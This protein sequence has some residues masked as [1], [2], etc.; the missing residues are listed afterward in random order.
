MR[1]AL[2]TGVAL[3]LKLKAVEWICDGRSG[4]PGKS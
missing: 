2:I 3:C 4:L 1:K